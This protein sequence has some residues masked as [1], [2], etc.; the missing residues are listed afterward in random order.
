MAI[1]I[2]KVGGTT[3]GDVD[4]PGSSTDN[5]VAR[6]DG[7]GGKTLQDS[8]VTVDDNNNLYSNSYRTTSQ[9]IAF[10]TT[11][12]PNINSGAIMTCTVTNTM[13][14]NF[15]SNAQAGQHF[16]LRLNANT[17]D[18]TIALSSSYQF[19]GGN[20]PTLLAASTKMVITGICISASLAECSVRYDVKA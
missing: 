12:T 19:A 8:G 5:A 18:Q 15:I 14:I 11:I 10:S 3:G 20:D 7:A 9:T 6:F 2:K 16:Y 17:T 4:G 1:D 13:N